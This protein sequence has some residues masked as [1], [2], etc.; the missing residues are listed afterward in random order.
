[1]GGGR[2]AVLHHLHEEAGGR[3]G[4]ASLVGGA[5]RVG[6][7]SGVGGLRG[8]DHLRLSQQQRRCRLM[9]MITMLLLLL[10]LSFALI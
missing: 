7:T 4:V 2:V 1:M 9:L 3:R 6:R 10:L 5:V 8:L